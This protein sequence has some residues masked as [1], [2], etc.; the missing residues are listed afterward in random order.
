[1]VSN[2][3]FAKVGFSVNGKQYEAVR[4]IDSKGTL[5]SKFSKIVDR[6]HIEIAAGE[7]KQFGESMTFEV[8]KTI[9]LDFEKIKNS[10]YCSTRGIKC[11]HQC[12]TKRIQRTDKCNHWNRHA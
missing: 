12:K 11:N 6:E 9:G 5:S 10:I 1:M 7:R 2:Q 8:E 4:K 3:G